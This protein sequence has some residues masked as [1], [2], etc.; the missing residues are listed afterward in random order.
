[1][2]FY[3]V[4]RFLIWKKLLETWFEARPTRNFIHRSNRKRFSNFLLSKAQIR[5]P[6]SAPSL[7][8][9]QWN[10]EGSLWQLCFLMLKFS[11]NETWAC[12]HRAWLLEWP[13]APLVDLTAKSGATANLEF[14]D[15]QVGST[16]ILGSWPDLM[17]ASSS[18]VFQKFTH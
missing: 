4:S 9:Y 14:F 1:M 7:H 12:D 16:G 18:F 17:I 13:K 8:A 11:K 5:T 10:S 15:F 6:F 2:I 3:F